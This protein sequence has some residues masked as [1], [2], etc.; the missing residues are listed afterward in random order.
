VG[1]PVQVKMSFSFSWVP[2]LHI[3]AASTTIART[4]TMRIEVPPTSSFFSAGCS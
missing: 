1:D 3:A 4:A 2:V